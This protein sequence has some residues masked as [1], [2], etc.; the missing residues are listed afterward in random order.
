MDVADHNRAAWD[1]AV[2]QGDR[3]T[4]GMTPEMIA[5]AR[6]GNWGIV[7]TYTTP[8]PRDWFPADM[9][10]VRVLGLASGGGQQGPLL[11]AAGAD[12]TIFDN[13]PNQLAQDRAVAEREGLTIHTVQ[14]D[15]RDLS[16]FADA[17]FDLIVHPVSNVFVPDVR[18]V[19]R[20]AYR[21]LRHG[22]ALLAGFMNGFDYL[23]DSLK[24]DEGT[25]E[26]RYQLPYSDLTS[27][28]EAEH[29][30]LFGAGAMYEFGHSLDDQIG[31]QLAAGFFIAGF[32][33]E[34]KTG[35]P[36]AEWMPSFGATRAVKL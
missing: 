16:A 23:F 29:A 33:E 1:E 8:A 12:V 13:S 6:V 14:G 32:Y 34:R 7:L 11:A 5:A 26:V 36:I 20:E 22:G 25:F 15:M 18:P 3:W 35:Q 9:R 24:A 10:G 27:V 17:S 4:V 2:T 31:G 21:V 28:T 30:R 19:W